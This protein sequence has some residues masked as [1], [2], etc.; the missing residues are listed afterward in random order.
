MRCIQADGGVVL[1]LLASHVGIDRCRVVTG[2]VQD[3]AAPARLDRRHLSADVGRVDLHAPRPIRTQPVRERWPCIASLA[4]QCHAS[5]GLRHGELVTT[6]ALRLRFHL[7]STP[8]LSCSWRRSAL[9]DR[10]APLRCRACTSADSGEQAS[11][12][13]NLLVLIEGGNVAECAHGRLGGAECSEGIPA[14][15]RA[16]QLARRGRSATV[17]A[18]SQPRQQRLADRTL[19]PRSRTCLPA[20]VG[21][22]VEARGPRY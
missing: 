1:S 15:V 8:W 2:T 12:A 4:L 3:V 5:S 11:A 9:D 20:L 21:I 19:E 10:G 18:R 13:C 22:D 16:M 17:V 7:T 6:T 14:S